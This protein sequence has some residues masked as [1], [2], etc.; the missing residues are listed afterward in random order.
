MCPVPGP[1][2]S[3]RQP[4][5]PL[6][7]DGR[8]Q[9]YIQSSRSPGIAMTIDAAIAALPTVRF[10]PHRISR[11]IIGGNQ[12]RGFS[13][14]S[15]ELDQQMRDYH[16][17]DNTVAM[18]LHAERCGLDTMQSRGDPVIYERLRAYRERGGTMKWV[19][20]TAGEH[21]DYFGNVRE[22]AEHQPIAI[23]HHGSVSDRMWQEGTFD[24]V[25]DRL[26]AIRD[27][28]AMVGIA[29]H[30][31]DIHRY[32]EDNG[33]DV[34]FYMTCFYNLSR[35]PEDGL[36]A[37]GARP[38]ERFDDADRDTICTFIRQTAKPCIA[39]KILAARRKC[40]SPADVKGAFEYAFRHIKP[41]DPV[42]VGMFQQDADQIAMNAEI[43]REL[44]T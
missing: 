33:W 25:E 9:G 7:D 17:V 40:E 19:C 28:G 42:N 21:P 41:D 29:A 20:Q 16:T 24:Q 44:L 22:I 4:A 6:L 1:E 13:H 15:A 27:T 39:Y 2:A 8:A 5:A 10:G 35:Q 23:F 14:W 43:V 3:A 31:P 32:V 36:L 18:W 12:I 11:L 38:R 30:I 34:D 26:K 37:D